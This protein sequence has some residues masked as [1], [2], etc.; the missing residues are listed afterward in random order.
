M[1]GLSLLFERGLLDPYARHLAGL[2]ERLYPAGEAPELLLW[3]VALTAHLACSRQYVCLKPDEAPSLAALLQV[4]VPEE[5][6]PLGEILSWRFPSDWREQLAAPPCERAVAQP[7]VAEPRPLVLEGRR[8]Y[9]HRLW[10]DEE[11]LTRSLL[12][13]TDGEA[14]STGPAPLRTLSD[15]ALDAA[16]AE[17]VE[18]AFR[19]RFSLI[20]GG[21]GTGKTTVVALALAA[22]LSREPGLRI[23]LCA[24]TGKTQARLKEAL[25]GEVPHIADASLR[26]RISALEPATIHR[27]LR[28]SPAKGFGVTPDNPL[29]ADVLVVDEVSMVSISLLSHLLASAPASCRVILLGDRDQL[30]AVEVGSALADMTD[31]WEGKPFVTRLTRSYRFDDS[32]GIG[33]LKD[34]VNRGDADGAW[35]CLRESGDGTLGYA[36]PPENERQCLDLLRERIDATGFGGYLQAQEP[37]AAFEAFERLRVL[38]ATRQGFLGAENLNRLMQ[39]L[40]SVRTAGR[41]YPVMIT[42]NDYTL[43]LFNGDVGLTLPAPDGTLKVC[44]PDPD[45]PGGYRFFAPAM[46]PPNEPV[47]AM[48]VHK[49]QGS[50]FGEVLLALPRRDTPVLTREWVYTGITRARNRC[51]VWAD[52][53]IWGRALARVTVRMSGLAE[54]LATRGAGHL[55][56]QTRR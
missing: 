5:D 43:R 53:A 23:A 2:V 52:R 44:F 4:P 38:C 55:L 37:A 7:P 29:A 13:L 41:G 10:F 16:Q 39:R 19:Y 21:P 32:R 26:D 11:Q 27:L 6:G 1:Q 14:D 12:R 35:E 45:K 46:L 42:T 17:A 20:T 34:A 24:P 28:S 36:E 30:A 48:T 40:L 49:A 9:L 51:T 8:L 18:R 54:K 25:V 22:L 3:A 15:R 56:C 50:G 47:F 33:R 31:A